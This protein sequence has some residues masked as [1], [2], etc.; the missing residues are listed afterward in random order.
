MRIHL[1]VILV[2]GWHTLLVQVVIHVDVHV[3]YMF[4]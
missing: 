3:W 1:V 2:H 4:G